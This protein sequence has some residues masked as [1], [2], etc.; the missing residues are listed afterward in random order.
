VAFFVLRQPPQADTRL[1]LMWESGEILCGCEL[2]PST[3]FWRRWTLNAL[4]WSD[5]VCQPCVQTWTQ[6]QQPAGH[7]VTV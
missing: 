4:N 3:R 2:T 5:L 7:R 1:H 6:P